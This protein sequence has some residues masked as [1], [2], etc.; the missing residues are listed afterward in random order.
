MFTS[1]LI[2]HIHSSAIIPFSSALASTWENAQAAHTGISGPV[3]L[4][5][6][7]VS[8]SAH[9]A[10]CVDMFF[11]CQDGYNLI[12]TGHSLGGGLA[13]VLGS[14]ERI[15]TL[16]WMPVGGAFTAYRTFGFAPWRQMFCVF[17][18][19]QMRLSWLMTQTVYRSL[20]GGQ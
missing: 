18:M 15:P 9:L 2:I 7:P 6:L 16:V 4:D 1:T 20:L 10:S 14:L 3:I 19:K 13:Q 5:L 12:L 8:L 11:R 17:I